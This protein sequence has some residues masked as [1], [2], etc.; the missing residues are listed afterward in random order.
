MNS[1]VK[2]RAIQSLV[3]ESL[4]I[5]SLVI[6]SLVIELLSHLDHNDSTTNELTSGLE[7]DS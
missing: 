1:G 6:E 7:L 5:E 2:K 3:I 4:V